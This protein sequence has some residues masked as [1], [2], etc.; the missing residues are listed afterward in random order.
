MRQVPDCSVQQI[1][2]V[3]VVVVVVHEV[4]HAETVHVANGR[5][6]DQILSQWCFGE[7]HHT[8][9]TLFSSCHRS[10]RFSV[11]DSEVADVQ[12]RIWESIRYTLQCEHGHEL[13]WIY[14]KPKTTARILCPKIACLS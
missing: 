3:V 9:S 4:K 8:P 6:G 12:R 7:R 14:A 13:Q 1:R 10:A 11:R 2:I 5:I